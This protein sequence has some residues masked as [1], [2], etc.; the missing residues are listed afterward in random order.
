MEIEVKID[1][2]DWRL[3][4]SGRNTGFRYVRQDVGGIDMIQRDND[5]MRLHL[6][7]AG[8][9][10]SK[11][12]MTWTMSLT[13]VQGVS[14]VRVVQNG[15]TD[16]GAAGVSK[17]Q[18][19]KGFVE[20]HPSIMEF[21]SPEMFK[22]IQRKANPTADE[23]AILG[24][25]EGYDIAVFR[26]HADQRHGD[27]GTAGVSHASGFVDT[28]SIRLPKP[29]PERKVVIW[30]DW[31]EKTPRQLAN[32]AG[33]GLGEVKVYVVSTPVM[34]QGASSV[35]LAKQFLNITEVIRMPRERSGLRKDN[36]RVPLAISREVHERILRELTAREAVGMVLNRPVHKMTR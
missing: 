36:V 27:L 16:C 25:T 4:L 7:T 15:H 21:I 30:T 11:S 13:E 28:S 17:M 24:Q 26:G 18:T 2:M 20:R 19:S 1:C 14:G 29:L 8:G 32:K 23:L 31:I 33:I 5:V 10:M 35:D 34:E 9:I 22:N 3:N 6:R 12:V